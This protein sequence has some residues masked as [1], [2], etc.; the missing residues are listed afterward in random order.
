MTVAKIA[1]YYA[2]PG[3]SIESTK[4]LSDKIL[5]KERFVSANVKTLPSEK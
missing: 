3:L 2:L 1:D 4:L 5:M